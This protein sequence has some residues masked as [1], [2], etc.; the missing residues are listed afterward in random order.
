MLAVAIESAREVPAPTR[1]GTEALARAEQLVHWLGGTMSR[2][3]RHDMMLFGTVLP[4]AD[5]TPDYR[6]EAQP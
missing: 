3:M 5:V 2:G 1:D 6:H 4:V